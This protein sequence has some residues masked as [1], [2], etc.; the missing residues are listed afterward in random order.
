MVDL[1]ISEN[2]KNSSA[3]DFSNDSEDEVDEDLED[4]DFKLLKTK[5]K[6][7]VKKNEHL[8]RIYVPKETVKNIEID[9]YNFDERLATFIT[10][11]PNLKSI[12]LHRR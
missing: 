6:V 8:E 3:M 2:K 5:F 11:F 7:C 12:M 1:P 9:F 10:T 4:F